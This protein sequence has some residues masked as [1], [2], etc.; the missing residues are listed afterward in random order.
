M[1]KI[2]YTYCVI[3]Y[4]HDPAAGEVLNVGI[5][6]C[7]PKSSY[8]AV[9]FEYRYERLSEA[10]VNFD[11]D[12]YRSTLHQ[13]E[14]AIFKLNDRLMGTLFETQM[15]ITDAAQLA[16]QVIPDRGLSVQFGPILAG[17]TDEIRSEHEYIFDRMVSSQ[18]PHKRKDKR[19]DEEV[20]SVYQRKLHRQKVSKYLRPKTFVSKNYD[21]RFDHAFKNEKWH[22]LEPVSMDYVRPQGIQ[23]RATKLLGE[24]F[25]L[26]GNREV[27]KLYLLLG[28]P[29]SESHQAAYD[30]AKTLLNKI[31]IKHQ[32]IEEDE[33]DDFAEHLADYMRRHGIATNG[34]E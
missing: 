17:I 12:H 14:A 29:Q 32:I 8:M 19:S 26:S 23:E 5:L 31:P 21:L 9:L 2:P 30:K 27:G 10:F 25:V 6:V 28:A 20:W 22:V 18:Y 11:G 7:A 1:N 4:V 33:A 3:R 16:A 15:P 13:L 34:S 24:T